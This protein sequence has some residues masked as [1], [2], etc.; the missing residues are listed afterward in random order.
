MIGGRQTTARR[1]LAP[2]VRTDKEDAPMKH[3]WATLVA[4]TLAASSVAAPATSL[5]STTEA[6]AE[7]GGTTLTLD[8]LG[9]PLEIAVSLDEIGHITE[10][11]ISDTDFSVDR[12][13][14]HKVRFSNSDDSTRI[15]VRAKKHKLRTDVK[16][17]ALAG[18]LGTH[19]WAGKLFGSD[20]DTIVTFD[21]V[22]NASGHP[23]LDNV[24][25]DA[26]FPA[27]A[28]ATVGT[29]EN[30]VGADEAESKVE[31]D[32]TWNG[33]EMRL[34]IKA[35]LH[36]DGDDRPAHLRVELKGKDRQRLALDNLGELVGD[37]TWTGHLCDGT[38]IAVNYTIADDPA[39]VSFGSVDGVGSD[40]FEVKEKGHGFEVRFDDSKARVRVELKQGSNG[41][42]ELR[43]RS[44]TTEKCDHHDDEDESDHEKRK[45]DDD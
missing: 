32:L 4:L 29:V 44:K 21:V 7:T 39:G 23:E 5:A 25:V 9:S 10:V 16:A 14:E 27:D 6:I 15:E 40:A 37:H 43:V 20:Q 42:W 26:L 45:D 41:D 24:S 33:F 30:E 28:T 22:E 3:R 31:I 36:L 18:I 12:G 19:E 35:E 34:K 11:L 8:I 17:D 2:D 1:E 13:D 38:P